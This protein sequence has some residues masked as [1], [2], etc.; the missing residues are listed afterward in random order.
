MD[1]E[2]LATCRLQGPLQKVMG[3]REASLER[4]Q[5]SGGTGESLGRTEE[6]GELEGKGLQNAGVE[7]TRVCV[8]MCSLCV[9]CACVHAGTCASALFVG[10]LV[11]MYICAVCAHVYVYLCSMLHVH[12]C[13]CVC[14]CICVQ[15]AS[16]A[17]ACG[18]LMDQNA[19]YG[20]KTC[21]SNDLEEASRDEAC[22]IWR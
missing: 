22:H 11:R 21:W 16:C 1:Q 9:T 6:S 18:P 12:L 2:D 8:C 20:G 15:H 10:S 5:E 3:C 17:H 4:V 14:V 7:L 19:D 13:A